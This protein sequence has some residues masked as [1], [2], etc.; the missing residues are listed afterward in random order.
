VGRET[1][2]DRKL[3]QDGDE[4]IL[5]PVLVGVAEHEIERPGEGRD[6]LVGVGEAGVDEGVEPASPSQGREGIENSGKKEE[7]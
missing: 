5:V 1:A 7:F 4:V 3:G 2:A 6:E